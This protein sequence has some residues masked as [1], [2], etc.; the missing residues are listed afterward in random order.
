MPKGEVRRPRCPSAH[1]ACD[2]EAD[3]L[4]NGEH[5]GME[6]AAV[7]LGG[8]TNAERGAITNRAE[9]EGRE[10]ADVLLDLIRAGLRGGVHN[11]TGGVTGTSVQAGRIDGDLHF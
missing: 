3:H 5:A 6:Q 9:N 11:V 8:L 2:R 1:P 10:V 4:Y 7:N